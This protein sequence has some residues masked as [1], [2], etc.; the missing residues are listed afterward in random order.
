MAPGY[1]HVALQKRIDAA[2]PHVLRWAGVVPP[3][4]D[5]IA[6]QKLNAVLQDTRPA[7]VYAD[8]VWMV[9]T[10]RKRVIIAEIQ[11]TIDANKQGAWDTYMGNLQRTYNCPVLLVIIA[12]KKGVH[13]WA[14][15]VRHRIERSWGRVVV[16]GPDHL[17]HVWSQEAVQRDFD[18]ASFVAAI[19]RS[20]P[21]LDKLWAEM[22]RRHRCDAVARTTFEEYI[23]FLETI[24]PTQ[25]WA[26]LTEHD[27][28]FVSTIEKTKQEYLQRGEE[29]GMQKGMQKGIQQGVR[30]GRMQGMVIA[31]RRAITQLAQKRGV[32]LTPQSIAQVK[33]CT[34]ATQLEAW[35]ALVGTTEQSPVQLNEHTVQ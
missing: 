3:S 13:R 1:I 32:T 29:R 17:P 31:Y 4:N 30:Q 14:E 25:W 9:H 27:M 19:T 20:A 11:T 2:L 16:L 7:E 6:Y 35:L 22:K 10:E 15:G 33:T 18:A 8:G 5:P 21:L 26:K 24:A 12:T 23:G 28:E 34:D